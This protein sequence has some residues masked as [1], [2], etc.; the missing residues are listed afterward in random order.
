MSLSSL[1][2]SISPIVSQNRQNRSVHILQWTEK[3]A[4]TVEEK[5]EKYLETLPSDA[6]VILT[7]PLD[8]PLPDWEK[9][10]EGG[11]KMLLA[12]ERLGLRLAYVR[13]TEESESETF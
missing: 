11:I 6:L 10:F 9:K 13:T 8:W 4:K 12:K 2:F 5:R 3:N 1:P 7:W